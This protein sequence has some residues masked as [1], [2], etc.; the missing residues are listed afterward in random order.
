MS[1]AEMPESIRNKFKLHT[2]SRWRRR[3][4]LIAVLT[5]GLLVLLFITW[6][7]FFVY[8]PANQHLV[9]TAREG[10]PLPE[11]HV[12]AEPGEKGIQR[13]V[14]GE[15]WHFVLPIVYSAV[16]EP[17]T[18]IPAGQVG[19]VTARGGQT[20]ADGRVLA[21]EGERG[22]QRAVLTPGT[23]RLNLHG[24]NVET[25]DAIEIRPGYVG[26]LQ[27]LLGKDGPGRFANAP[28][29]K[30]ILR[31]VLQP[32]MYYI[33]TKE[34]AVVP[35]KVGIFQ[36]SFH[37]DENVDDNT[38][39][40]F[41]SKG[42][43]HIA[44]DCTVEWEVLP[45]DM[46][47][48]VA[49]YGADGSAIER[50]VIQV[51]AHAIGR[52]KGI[53][54]GVQDF[55][56]GSKR[57]KFQDDFTNELTRVCGGKHVTVHSAFIRNIV[58]PENYLKPIRDKQIAAETQIT[59]KAKEA[60]AQSEAEVERETQLIAQRQ[61]EVAAETAKLVAAIDR[62][63]ENTKVRTESEVEKLKAEYDAQ[64]AALDA[65]RTQ[66]TGEAKA[67]VEKQIE[68]AKSSLYRLKMDV[69]H[70]NGDAFLRYSMAQDLNPKMMLRLFHAGPGTFWTNLD[71][72]NKPMTLMLPMPAQATAPPTE[73]PK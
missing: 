72:K 21:N 39:I 32:G 10:K 51:Q 6:N 28:D 9:I 27:R 25:V 62:E 16:L 36:T 44:M 29:E 22:I 23:Y 49:Q 70:N 3:L 40:T 30:G 31:E 5:I 53:D 73:A 41:V 14:Q 17:N 4:G 26:V 19:I 65:Q 57:E 59:T 13:R 15:G 63:V 52:D 43:F 12:L 7:E 69:F 50:Q 45:S 42:G 56:E 48:L 35:A 61:A 33:N 8:V 71:E 64:I 54:Y 1:F 37:Y 66:V 68:T 55:L 2:G 34:F 24:Y 20:P 38:A 18:E 67:E 58:I 46:P 47:E 11:G 60:T